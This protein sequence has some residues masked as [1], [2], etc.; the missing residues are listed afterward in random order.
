MLA[1]VRAAQQA[2]G[3]YVTTNLPII[4]S[5]YGGSREQVC[6]LAQRV[7]E[8][9]LD[10]L[11][12]GDGMIGTASYPVW[13]GGLDPFVEIAWLASRYEL[14]HYGIEGIVLPDRDPRIAAKQASS[15]A[16]IT[17]GRF[18]LGI[19][20]GRWRHDATLFGYDFDKRGSRVDEGIRALLS[21]WRGEQEFSGRYWR[22]SCDA[23][24]ITPCTSVPAPELWLAGEGQATIGRCI[25][26][27][28]PWMPT[29]FTPS[30]LAPLAREYFDRGGASLKVRIR[31]SAV[32]PPQKPED[33]LSYPTLI[34]PPEFLAEQIAAYE[35]LGADYISVVPGFD[36]DSAA[37][38]IDAMG[39]AKS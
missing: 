27:H 33:R 9:G 20:S 37:A 16:A 39:A 21:I 29:R 6:Q 13:Q 38:T 24:T 25:K 22:W 10:G 12:L 23:G 35:E 28:L 7:V 19:V 4:V 15:L 5:P 31:M 26:Y 11:S 1:Q 3:V 2:A 17:E 8:A 34:G 14:A 32:E 30:D 36:F 18:H